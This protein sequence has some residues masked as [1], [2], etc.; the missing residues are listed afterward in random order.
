MTIENSNKA[1]GKNYR[2]RVFEIVRQI[3]AGKVMTYG[4]IAAVLGDDYTPRTVGFAMHAAT[5]DVPWQ[6]VVNAKGGCSTKRF[7]LPFDLQ[8]KILESE[9][10]TFNDKA[11]CDLEIYRWSPNG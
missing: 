11:C 9:G 8:Q 5:E 1:S 4:Q 6:R 10:V 3:P 7:V 2:E